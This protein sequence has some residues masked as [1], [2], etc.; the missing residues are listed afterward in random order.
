MSLAPLATL[1]RQIFDYVHGFVTT[2]PLGIERAVVFGALYLPFIVVVVCLVVFLVE[3]GR[4]RRHW[5]LV[6]FLASLILAA[7][8]FSANLQVLFGHIRPFEALQFT[9]A[10]APVIFFSFPSWHVSVLFALA[11]TVRFHHKK[12]GDVLIFLALVNGLARVAAGVHWPFDILGGI[13][14]GI[15][16]ALMAHAIVRFGE[17]TFRPSGK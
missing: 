5:L 10:I 3:H 8:V 15:V 4:H 14:V 12:T 11:L 16:S 6:E 9:P 13:A 17:E 7:Q 1:N 2:G